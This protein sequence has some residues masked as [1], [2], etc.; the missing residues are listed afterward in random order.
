MK[1]LLMLEIYLF[2]QYMLQEIL[3]VPARSNELF[4]DL[5][6]AG[7]VGAVQHDNS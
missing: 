7:F 6:V 1:P 5:T 3:R 2:G 4:Q